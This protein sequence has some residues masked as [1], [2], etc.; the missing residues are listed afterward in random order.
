MNSDMSDPSDPSDPSDSVASCALPRLW[1]RDFL[2][3]WQGQLVSALGD[4]VYAIALGFW[5]LAKTGSTALMGTLMAV[6]T[7]PRIVAAP[8]AGVLV[9]RSERKWLLVLMD[10]IRG[11]VVVAVGV[12][13]FTGFIQIW[14][15]FVAGI[16][17]GL[18]GALF[19]PGV[20]SAVPDIVPKDKLVQANSA[21]SLIY[22]GSGIV[23]NSAGGFLYQLLGAPLMFL[24]NGISYLVSAVTL[25]FIRIP[26]VVSQRERQHFMADLKDGMALVW[27][28]AGL[29][30]LFL[31]ASVLNF[32]AVIGITLLLPLFQKTEGLGPGRYGIAMA[33][34]TGGMFAGFLLTS[35]VRIVPGARFRAF[36]LG[37]FVMSLGLAVFA[38]TDVFPLML[39]LVLVAGV[40]NAVVN[41]L[42]PATVQMAVPQDMRGK[43]FSLLGA[44]SG[45]LTPIAMALAGV[46]AEVIPLRPL[47]SGSFVL[48]F[49]CFVP[50]LFSPALRKFLNFDP[51]R[52]TIESLAG[53]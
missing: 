10:I 9:D 37:G 46:L 27:K 49:L 25:L 53:Q 13:A 34:L 21:Y 15:V 31:T 17:I 32:F 33:V 4:T 23:G 50:L 8:F 11:V 36:M 40:A 41:S 29:R 19:N 24:V 45:G 47:I 35:I 51:E 6:S 43:V 16:I 52:E 22:T 12:A 48:T 28:F 7:L 1:N 39:G 3:L 14:M 26:P 20:S 38:L 44:I 30:L 42:I 2:L 5:I 18:G